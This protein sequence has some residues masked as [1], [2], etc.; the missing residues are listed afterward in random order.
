M[1]DEE[2]A[3][4]APEGGS[5]KANQ[6]RETG[7]KRSSSSNPSYITVEEE[8]DQEE[9]E[10]EEEEQEK[11]EGDEHEDEEETEEHRVQ[12]W[13]YLEVELI[14]ELPSMTPT[15]A[16]TTVARV[17]KLLS[18][19]RTIRHSASCC[20]VKAM[21][22]AGATMDRICKVLRSSV[23]EGAVQRV[24]VVVRRVLGNSLFMCGVT[25]S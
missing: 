25:H 20:Q 15:E 17:I 10:E 13:A 21:Y 16:A 5:V 7:S 8:G 22:I 23:N 1:Q 19:S 24:I 6:I 18:Q 2:E 11:E 9:E 12:R 3:G 14:K 4:D